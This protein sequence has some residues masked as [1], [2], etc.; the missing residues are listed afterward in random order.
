MSLQPKLITCGKTMALSS[1]AVRFTVGPTVVAV[2]SIAIGLRGDLLRMF[3]LQ[4]YTLRSLGTGNHRDV[5][6]NSSDA[7][8]SD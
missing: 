2:T 4:V 5:G 6:I 8:T 7:V 3:I 1:M